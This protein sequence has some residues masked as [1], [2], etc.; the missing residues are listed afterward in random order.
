MKFLCG[1]M[2]DPRPLV[3]HIYQVWINKQLKHV[4]NKGVLPR[5]MQAEELFKSLYRESLVELPG[6]PLH[7]HHINY[8]NH[9]SV[10]NHD[11]TPVHTPSKFYWFR[12]MKENITLESHPENRELPDCA[13]W[14]ETPDTTVTK[15][16]LSTCHRISQLQ[17]VTDLCMSSVRSWPEADVFCMSKRVQT[18]TLCEC[19][20]PSS[21]V[22]HLVNLISNLEHLE[23]N[24]IWQYTHI[25]SRDIG[26]FHVKM[27]EVGRV[28]APRNE[29]ENLSRI[30]IKD[31]TL[32]SR[33]VIHLIRQIPGW[34]EIRTEEVRIRDEETLSASDMMFSLN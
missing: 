26:R 11:L 24:R 17:A 18:I 9:M 14:I 25:H 33:A 32:P 23:I 8:Y 21:T 10:T 19:T 22:N 28:N 27:S 31:C 2:S 30:E 34:E 29:T 12:Y 6:R 13:M 7:N 3:D 1:L 15:R 5:E 20:I 16:L 4:R